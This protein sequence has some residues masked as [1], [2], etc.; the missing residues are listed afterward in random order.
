MKKK[1]AALTA[2]LMMA[3]SALCFASV[4]SGSV[5]LEGVAPGSSVEAAKAKQAFDQL[6]VDYENE[7]KVRKAE[8]EQQRARVKALEETRYLFADTSIFN[9]DFN[10]QSSFRSVE[11]AK[12]PASRKEP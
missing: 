3:A 4:P 2:G 6:K 1:T 10:A 12:I 5:A 7:S 9:E 8:L 11:R